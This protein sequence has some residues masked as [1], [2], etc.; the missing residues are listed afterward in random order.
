MNAGGTCA[1]APSS[2]R[3][4][5]GMAGD[6][7]SLSVERGYE[8]WAPSYDDAPNPLLARE[9]RYLLPL[10]ERVRGKQVL[11]LACGT[12]RWLDKLVRRGA[13][14]GV[15]IDCSEAMLQIARKKR[16]ISARILQASSEML[17]L[18]GSAFDLAVCSF[19]LGHFLDLGTVARE[20]AR[21][22]KPGAELLVSDLHPDAYA[23]GWRVGFR[24]GRSAFQITMLPR[25][26]EEIVY[27]FDSRGFTCLKHE[28]L[29]LGEPEELLFRKA[30]KSHAFSRACELPAVFVCCFRRNRIPGTGSRSPVD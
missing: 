9:E 19:A 16:P 17:P 8:R 4:E 12:G 21:V 18:A 2:R 1:V 6:S 29:F 27:T 11:D 15:G 5:F 26:I 24:D 25:A 7:Q 23:K 3:Q 10:L 14:F 20:L 28:S 13:A 22:M 30:E